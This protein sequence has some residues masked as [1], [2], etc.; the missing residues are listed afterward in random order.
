[1]EYIRQLCFSLIVSMIVMIE[2]PNKVEGRP[3]TCVKG[4]ASI[5]DLT[6]KIG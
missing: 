2:R 3:E 4:L 5:F 1:M 6:S